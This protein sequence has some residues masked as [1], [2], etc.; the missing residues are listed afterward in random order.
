[1]KK[2]MFIGESLVGKSSLIRELSGKEYT[3]RRAM[4]VEYFGQY[5]NTPGEFIENR[6]FYHALITSSAD[7]DIIAFVQDAS[8]KSS[9]LPP[10]FASMFNRKV[11]GIVSKIDHPEA[12][13]ERAQ[14]FLQNAGVKEFY[15]TSS[16]SGEGLDNLRQML[17]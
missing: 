2:M 10:L 9:L 13:I 7:C 3:S 16:I 6:R 14:L 11:I 1:M 8:R 15:L 4:A 5:I 17:Q 12:N